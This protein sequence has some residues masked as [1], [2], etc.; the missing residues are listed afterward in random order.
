MQALNE[1]SN[2]FSIAFKENYD[3]FG[4][5]EHFTFKISHYEDG[6][7]T[8]TGRDRYDFDFEDDYGSDLMYKA[9]IFGN[10]LATVSNKLSI[11]GSGAIHSYYIYLE[12][13]YNPYGG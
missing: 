6:I 13:H 2:Q 12:F 11:V 4:A 10:N 7:Y 5:L 1:E 3:I 9:A 8:I